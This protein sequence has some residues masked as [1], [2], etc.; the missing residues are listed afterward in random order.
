[1]KFILETNRLILREITDGDFPMLKKVIRDHDGTPYED[2]YVWKWLNWCKDCYQKYNFGLWAVINKETGEMIGNCGV[3]MQF[4]DDEWKP[5]IGY[6]LRK[7]FHRQGLGKEA[8]QAIRDYFFTHY[9]YDEVY[10]YMNK[11]NVAS[12]KTAEANGMTYQHLYTSE[13]GHLCRVYK[14]TRKEWENLKKSH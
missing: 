9:D 12:Y 6:H 11:D 2:E 14:I 5:E 1:M 8:T 13:D 4:I 7:D 10:S 3:S